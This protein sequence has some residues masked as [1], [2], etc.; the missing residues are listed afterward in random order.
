MTPKNSMTPKNGTTVKMRGAVLYTRVSTGEQD[1]YGTSPETQRAAC[2]TKAQE[3]SLPIIAEYHDGGISGG[4]LLSR[5]GFQA[6][7]TDIQEGR[8]DTLICP[9]ISR[10]SRDVEHQQAVKKSVKAAGGQLVFCDMNFE[11]TPEGDLNFTIQGGFAEYEKAVIRKRTM[12]GKRKRAEDGQQPSRATSPF[13]Y[14]IVTKADVLRGDYPADQVGRYQVVEDQAAIVREIFARYASGGQSL[15]QIAK[16]LNT[17]SVK[18]PGKAAYWWA[19]GLRYILTNTAYRGKAHYGQQAHR[20]DESRL[21]QIN[22]ATGKPYKQT[23]VRQPS[24]PKDVVEL[25]CPAII[26]AATFDAVSVRLSGNKLDCGGNPERVLMLTGK[27][28]CPSCG[29]RMV[30]G[31][32]GRNSYVNVRGETLYY[33]KERRYLCLANTKRYNV[34]GEYSCT[35]AS[36]MIR[37]TEEAA[38]AAVAALLDAAKTPN[39]LQEALRAFR[40]TESAKRETPE[41]IGTETPERPGNERSLTAARQEQS[42]VEDALAHLEA[43]QE[44]AIEAQI[45][46]IMAG[47]EASAYGSVFAG[48]AAERKDLENR[49]S[50]L[51][52]RLKNG[53]LPPRQETARQKETLRKKETARQKETDQSAAARALA[54]AYEVLTSEAVP[55]SKKR[56]IIGTLV[57]KVICQKDGAKVVFLPSV[58]GQEEE[59]PI[60]NDP[61]ENDP[62][63]DIHSRR[64]KNS[65]AFSTGTLSPDAYSADTLQP[66]S[67]I[68]A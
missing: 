22:P 37:R 24:A 48:I 36:Y 44:A 1:K 31:A 61:Y 59:K 47:A 29:G 16:W 49:R 35:S 66:I 17:A 40:A 5:T 55:N 41:Q 50:Q 19:S 10:Y 33:P 28:F 15:N 13:G 20:K 21:S 2:R 67:I 64:G 62:S 38:V 56:A 25:A 42:K 30:S 3:L 54:L 34:T 18:T 68:L 52:R 51:A 14:R 23:V 27:V 39:A 7:L 63:G 4:F 8:A 45:A 65:A 11:D 32:G 60:G 53:N 26:G 58:I 12:S 6:A 9:S 43:R 46:G 57:D